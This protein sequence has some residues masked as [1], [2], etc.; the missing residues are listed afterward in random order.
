MT[1]DKASSCDLLTGAEVVGLVPSH[2]GAAALAID[3]FIILIHRAMA[4]RLPPLHPYQSLDVFRNDFG[5]E[6]IQNLR[7]T[8]SASV[9]VFVFHCPPDRCSCFFSE[10]LQTT[11]NQRDPLSI[12][13]W[14]LPFVLS[15]ILANF[16]RRS[17]TRHEMLCIPPFDA[18]LIVV[19]YTFCKVST[20]LPSPI[21]F[22]L[23]CLPPLIR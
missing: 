4:A 23:P 16:P 15:H 8:T 17:I 9:D 22:P 3:M 1:I 6:R 10:Y 19:V 5:L 13:V 20:S 14:M 2:H 21:W 11:D 18:S 12:L 7:I